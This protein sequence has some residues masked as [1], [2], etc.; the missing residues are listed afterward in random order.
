MDTTEAQSGE[1][2]PGELL[3]GDPAAIGDPATP[4]EG[5]DGTRKAILD[6]AVRCFTAQGWAGTNMSL[7]ARESGMTRGKIQYYFPVLEEL[8]FAAIE[9]L[10]DS[11]RRSYFDRISP[12][13]PTRVSFDRGVEVLW[14]LA[15]DPLH[16]A[17]AELEAAA[18]TDEGL[19]RR[20]AELHIADEEQVDR[21][22]RLTF[23]ALAA[24]GGHELHLGRY[25]STIFINGLAAHNFPADA[26]IWR[27]RLVAM[28]K[29]CLTD[30]WVRRGVVDLDGERPGASSETPAT[31]QDGS[32]PPPADSDRT[33]AA[34]A[35][36][37]QAM[38]MLSGDP[39]PSPDP[40][41]A[42]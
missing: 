11:W 5:S 30:F 22:T 1:M 35:L 15:R 38:E 24:V 29:E 25:F 36:L 8:K 31:E 12:D 4:G 28:L 39:L 17:M 40:E 2:L 13:A 32:L 19:R 14:E 3:S 41:M 7:V 33:Q 20:L 16:V 21:A 9:H 10:Y 23:P 18:R 26:P 37:R 42:D 34:L 6:A 27:A